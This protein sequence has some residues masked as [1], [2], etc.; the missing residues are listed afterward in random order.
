MTGTR[1]ALLVLQAV[2]AASLL[3]YPAILVANVMQIATEGPRGFERF[4]AA[5]PYV[6][7]SVYPVFWIGLFLVSWRAVAHG[8][9]TRAFVL[10]SVPAL[11]SLAAAGW[12]LQSGKEDRKRDEARLE[13]IQREVE[14]ANPLVWTVMRSGGPSEFPGAPILSADE[15]IAEISKAPNLNGA[16]GEWGTP[17]AIALR[18]LRSSRSQAASPSR[19]DRLRVVRQLLARGATLAPD[20]RRI[21]LY[22]NLL[23]QA[24]AE[25]PDTTASENPLV[26]R[27]LNRE[28]QSRN[29]FAMREDEVALLNSPTRLHGTPLWAALSAMDGALAANLI[30]AGARLSPEETR[31]PAGAQALTE[32][33]QSR[34]E[35]WSKYYR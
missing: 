17:L 18:Y 3:P 11:L 15:V 30:Q 34:K 28:V 31:D 25:G 19:E 8:A 20:E 2:G 23:R 10:S 6:L 26:S 13:R 27:I 24:T 32:L 1:I 14:A 35:L 22:A 4:A 7:L 16:A 5:L 29:P 21:L 12:F 33:F 9:T